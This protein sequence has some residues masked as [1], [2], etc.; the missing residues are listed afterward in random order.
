[1]AVEVAE[2]ALKK[3]TILYDLAPMGYFTLDAFGSISDLKLAVAKMLG[4]KRFSLINTNFK[5]FVAEEAKSVFDNFFD[6]AFKSNEKVSCEVMLG[7]NKS[8]LCYVYM[9]GLVVFDDQ[10]CFLSVVD[11]SGS[12]SAHQ[13]QIPIF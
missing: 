11:I 3:N 7:N 6:V 2:A 10:K 1:M 13:F 8:P 4:G 9:E 5:T 12:S